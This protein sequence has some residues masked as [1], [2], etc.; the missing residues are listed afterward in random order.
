DQVL[1]AGVDAISKL[2]EL[3]FKALE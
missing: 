1:D 3:Q 2:F